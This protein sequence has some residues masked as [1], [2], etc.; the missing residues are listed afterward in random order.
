MLQGFSRTLTA[1]LAVVLIIAGGYFGF[2]HFVQ[3]RL[4]D[5]EVNPAETHGEN[6]E[7]KELEPVYPVG[8]ITTD[9][10]IG[11][12]GTQRYLAAEIMFACGDN[13]TYDAL[14]ERHQAVR[15]ALLQLFRSLS[16]EHLQGKEGMEMAKEEIIDTVNKVVAPNEI[17]Q[18][19]FTELII[20]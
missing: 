6:P 17:L 2:T 15:D 10:H 3:P 7:Q 13:E 19:Y 18:V 1:G 12:D 5:E 14:E 9:L 11:T 16:A 4:S 8:E 20:Q